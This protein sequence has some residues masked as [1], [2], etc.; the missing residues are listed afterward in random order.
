M[1]KW[2]NFKKLVEIKE[3][4]MNRQ[5]WQYCFECRKKWID[6]GTEFV[7]MV[8]PIIQGKQ[9]TRFWCDKCLEEHKKNNPNE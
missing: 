2:E 5:C 8:L 4:L 1:K 3:N 6:T 7:H 9:E